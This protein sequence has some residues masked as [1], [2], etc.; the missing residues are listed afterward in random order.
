MVTTEAQEKPL[1]LDGKNGLQARG[2]AERVV[3]EDYKPSQEEIN[4]MAAYIKEALSFKEALFEM[5]T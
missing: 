5:G 2:I 3:E 4:L 1:F